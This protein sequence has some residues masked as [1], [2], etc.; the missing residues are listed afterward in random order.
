MGPP[1]P[2]SEA[3]ASRPLH[4]LRVHQ[5]ELEQQN[6]ELRQTQA[7]L[8][9]AHDAYVDLYEYAPVG[10]LTL[11]AT[12]LVVAANLRAARLLGVDRSGLLQRHFA[13]WVGDAAERRRWQG[14][15]EDLVQS[16]VQRPADAGVRQLE[17]VLQRV[18]G[19][20]IQAL[21][22]ALR[23]GEEGQPPTLR[24]ALNDISPLQQLQQALR[25]ST[26]RL[27][28]MFEDSGDALMLL[29]RQAFFDCNA[30]TLKLFGCPTRA[31]FLGLHPSELSPPTQPGG[32]SSRTLADA[33]IDT[34]FRLG[35]H[36]FEWRHC[37]LDGAEFEAE[38]LLSALEIQGKPALMASVHDISERKRLE[39][40]VIESR[41]ALH[42]LLDAMAEGAYGLD[43]QGLC[44]FANPAFLRM[45]GY[46]ATE[47]V[48]GRPL[49]E[50]I[51]YA[52]SDGSAYPAA[53]CPVHAVMKGREA[54]H[55]A[56]EVF[57]HRDG[58]PVP[59]ECWAHP[60]VQEGV[61]TGAM[62]TFIDI[63][64]R[65]AA[66]A[67]I[68]HLAFHDQLTQLP[69]RRLLQDR[70]EQALLT[71][72]RSRKSGA[73]LMLDLDHFKPLNDGH[74]HRV[75][76]LLLVEVARRLQQCVRKSDT[77][78]RYGGDEFVVIL[79]ELDASQAAYAAGQVAE[80]IRATLAQ[81]YRLTLSDEGGTG[82]CVEHRCTASIGVALFNRHSSDAD[83]LY[84]RADRAMYQAKAEGGNRGCVCE[85][86]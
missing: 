20:R 2:A 86:G 30:A 49:H 14:I 79:R 11:D 58:H 46:A 34:A 10:Y 78:A 12:G 51:H 9:A 69:N 38:V 43:S 35:S 81:P 29:D 40:A 74:G 65:L 3:E 68:H 66:E 77:V 5:I 28:S 32:E 31:D 75:G 15:F 63:T 24:L 44:T 7:E 55:S 59:V 4:E 25:E 85:L 73:L 50:L 22:D 82:I 71:C 80:T 70:L 56:D 33:R 62:V 27:A 41:E 42:R 45:L 23:L 72:E 84:S 19:G 53:D 57:W 54:Y 39:R 21:V 17:L 47:D 1:P 8:Q 37:R 67:Q 76:D 60:L 64:E 52:H 83:E 26:A 48:V 61:T 18:D 13:L 6:Q 36:R 16:P